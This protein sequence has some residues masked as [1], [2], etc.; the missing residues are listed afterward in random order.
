MSPLRR[1]A[2]TQRGAAVESNEYESRQ[3]N[4]CICMYVCMY[5]CKASEYPD[6]HMN[7][8]HVG[9]SW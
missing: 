4:V 8:C 2:V 5:V 1:V 7:A 6:E 3:Y 9:Q